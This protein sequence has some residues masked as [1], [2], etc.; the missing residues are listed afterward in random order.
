MLLKLKMLLN[1]LSATSKHNWA[2]QKSRCI[3][4][5]SEIIE[6]H[7]T[8]NIKKQKTYKNYGKTSS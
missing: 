6:L 4:L 3:V 1:E 8:A 5:V 7:E 2:G